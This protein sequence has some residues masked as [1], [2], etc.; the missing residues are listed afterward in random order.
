M[1]DLKQLIL[2]KYKTI[3]QFAD[4][5]NLPY[6]KVVAVINGREK[7]QKYVEKVN[8]IAQEPLKKEE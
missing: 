7:S 3:K 4:L 6:S 8:L 2:S 1:N 5:N